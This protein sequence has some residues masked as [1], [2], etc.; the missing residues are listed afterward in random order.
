MGTPRLTSMYNY[1]PFVEQYKEPPKEPADMV[2]CYN[3]LNVIETEVFDNVWSHIQSLS[4]SVIALN[5]MIPGIYTRKM[6]WYLAKFVN[7]EFHVVEACL[8]NKNL[9]VLLT[10]GKSDDRLSRMRGRV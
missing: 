8:K 5:I 10:K 9:F 3:V 2:V 1:D 6:E 7:C 4:K